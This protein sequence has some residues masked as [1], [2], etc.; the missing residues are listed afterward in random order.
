MSKTKHIKTNTAQNIKQ[1]IVLN[2]SGLPTHIYEA[3]ADA[4]NGEAC[5]V[6]RYEY[7]VIFT[8]VVVDMIEE[9]ST[10]DATWDI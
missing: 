6:T 7:D 5:L 3:R 2:A 1:H 4:A 10:W 9:D 8:A